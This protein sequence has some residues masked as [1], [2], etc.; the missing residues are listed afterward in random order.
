M[1]D[2]TIDSLISKSNKTT[3]TAALSL[4]RDVSP[5]SRVFLFERPARGDNARNIQVNIDANKNLAIQYAQ[6][7][8][9][10][11]K[12]IVLCQHHLP[13]GEMARVELFGDG[14]GVH[15]RGQ[16]GAELLTKSVIISIRQA[17]VR[18]ITNNQTARPLFNN[19]YTALSDLN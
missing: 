7:T 3:L 17:D 18:Q 16:R 12:I 14:D 8:K 1:N 13:E 4:A 15:F 10:Q 9:S 5:G 6:L 11:K 2:A 19:R